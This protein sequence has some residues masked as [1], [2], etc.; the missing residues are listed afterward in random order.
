MRVA[1][2]ALLALAACSPGAEETSEDAIANR[3]QEIEAAANASVNETIAQIEAQA[4]NEAP[5]VLDNGS[6]TVDLEGSGNDQ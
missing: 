5:P 6:V 4:A 2:G 1:V 3:A